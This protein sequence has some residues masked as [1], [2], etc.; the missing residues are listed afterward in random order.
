MAC[1]LLWPAP[2]SR[3]I[4]SLVRSGFARKGGER[5]RRVAMRRRTR[6]RPPLYDQLVLSLLGPP[7]APFGRASHLLLVPLCPLSKSFLSEYAH[8]RASR[9]RR[10]FVPTYSPF[11]RPDTNRPILP[12][13]LL[14]QLDRGRL[15]SWEEQTNEKATAGPADAG[16]DDASWVNCFL[17]LHRCH[18]CHVSSPTGPQRPPPSSSCRLS[19]PSASRSAAASAASVRWRA[20]HSPSAGTAA[21]PTS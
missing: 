7:L 17:L 4:P 18:V 1:T 14:P 13:S 11:F 2:F 16:T 8:P 9:G 12:P 3:P 20:C 10:P 19:S 6:S 21:S 5:A 15:A